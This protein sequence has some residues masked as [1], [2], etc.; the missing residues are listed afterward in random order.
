MSKMNSVFSSLT[1]SAK[2]G[3]LASVAVVA[4]VVG[5]ITITVAANNPTPGSGYG[6]PSA[7]QAV[8]RSYN[9]SDHFYTRDGGECNA[10]GYVVEAASAFRGYATS[11][12]GGTAVYRL[13]NPR[14]GDHF[15][16]V[17]DS[18]AGNATG[19]GYVREGV[20]FFAFANQSDPPNTISTIAVFRL[21][22]G[23]D[24]FYTTSEVERDVAIANSRYVSEGVGFY[25]P[26]NQ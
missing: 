8:C 19:G 24:H 26:T 12:A 18:E 7:S 1:G 2:T 20:G 17:N 25:T 10:P 21:Y 4:A 11:P 22:N 9:G 3:V 6:V 14:N 16:T 5:L 13:Y 23:R 15:Y